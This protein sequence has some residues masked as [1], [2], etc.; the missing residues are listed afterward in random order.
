M[1]SGQYSMSEILR[2]QLTKEIHTEHVGV[3]QACPTF[4]LA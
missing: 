3:G 2:K 4:L 1:R